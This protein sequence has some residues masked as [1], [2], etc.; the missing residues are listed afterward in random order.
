MHM[1][2][3]AKSNLFSSDEAVDKS[4]VA[5][6]TINHMEIHLLCNVI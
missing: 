5:K 2:T 1:N 3:E 4:N 6:V